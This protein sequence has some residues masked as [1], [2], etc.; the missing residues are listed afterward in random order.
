[1]YLD[2]HFNINIMIIFFDRIISILNNELIN[3]GLDYNSFQLIHYLKK[4][5]NFKEKE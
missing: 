3:L 5:N 2:H 1:M 4:I